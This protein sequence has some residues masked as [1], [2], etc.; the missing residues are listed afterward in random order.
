[1]NDQ[2]QLLERYLAM[3]R[4]NPNAEPPPELDTALATFARQMIQ[5]PPASNALRAR[6]WQQALESQA[7]PNGAAP[8]HD[9][10]EK[11][12]YPMQTIS[13]PKRRNATVGWSLLAVIAAV[14]AIVVWFFIQPPKSSVL[15]PA[16]LQTLSATETWTITP[17]FTIT[18]SAT[19]TETLTI[20]PSFTA[21]LTPHAL[22]GPIE[23]IPTYLTP[24]AIDAPIIE[25]TPAAFGSIEG[26]IVDQLTGTNPA[27]LY[28]FVAAGDGVVVISLS[29]KD[30]A[31]VNLK[32]SVVHADNNGG[33][34]GGGSGGGGSSNPLTM[35]SVG[36]HIL[37][38]PDDN[39]RIGVLS[40]TSYPGYS[41]DQAID[42]TL[43]IRYTDVVDLGIKAFDGYTDNTLNDF[44]PLALYKFE[45]NAGDVITIRATGVDGFDTGLE[46]YDSTLNPVGDITTGFDEN[47]GPG[48]D[49][50]IYHQIMPSTGIYYVLVRP[51]SVGFGSYRLQLTRE[52]VPSLNKGT[53]TAQFNQPFLP[54][55]TFDGK[56]DQTV[57]VNVT[58]P[59]D[60]LDYAVQ[61]VEVTF[62][63]D[64]KVIDIFK[65]D[66]SLQLT[67][68]GVV[69]S[70]NV[71]LQSD[72]PVFVSVNANGKLTR[73]SQQQFHL[74]VSVAK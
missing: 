24:P 52:T 55:F 35:Q 15:S 65:H 4:E 68:T 36:T 72:S 63:Q 46:L 56:K 30:L 74:E 53:Q 69:L 43:D 12:T 6:V 57:T 33:S 49:A 16:N 22:G 38:L 11:E 27:S 45:A 73:A 29:T 59:Q 48:Y 71:T 14:C 50:E 60:A 2:S 13:I 20:T 32:S 10:F 17:S 37:V 54:R 61:N 34:G 3:L 8:K 64:G 39:V 70:A 18:A 19:A 28:H 47:S 40:N 31:L 66:S 41:P 42:Y 5:T 44:N 51:G 58:L 21:T 62:E 23:I 7:H 1:M 9:Y 26:T 67:Q 25:I